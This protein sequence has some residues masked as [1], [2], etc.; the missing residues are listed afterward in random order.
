MN[1]TVRAL[2]KSR[3]SRTQVIAALA[4][5]QQGE[6]LANLMPVLLNNVDESA[7]AFSHELLYGTL[8]QWWALSRIVESLAERPVDDPMVTAAL[9]VGLYQLLYLETP[10]YA[11][12]DSTLQAL[13]TVGQG[14]ATGFV[15][16]I[17]RKVQKSSNTYTKK[18][19]QHHSLPNWLAK[20]LKQDWAD[21]YAM[22]GQ[23]LR[24]PAPIFLRVNGQHTSLTDYC[25]L[26]RKHD[27]AHEIVPIGLANKQTIRLMDKIKIQ[28]LPHF[29]EGW[30]SVQD[31]H[32]QIAGHLLAA[33]VFD[34][35]PNRGLKILD[36]CAAP[37]GKTAHLLEL[38]DNNSKKFH[39][40]HLIA[41]DNEPIRLQRLQD[42][43][44]RLD[45]INTSTLQTVCA[46]AT[47]FA[48]GQYDAILLDAP[49]T[50]T[51]VIRRH[52]D[53]TLLRQ[54]QDVSQTVAL[55]AAILTNVWR[56]LAPNGYLLYA[57]CSLLKAENE[58]QIGAFLSQQND[59]RVVPFDLN[60]PNQ[61]ATNIGYQCLPLDPNGG[62]GFYYAL[63][64]KNAP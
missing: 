26:L 41:I 19:A 43:I 4:Q 57:T 3:D 13:K 7:R 62:D 36:A 46:D 25:A 23:A 61:I 27:I 1:D 37:G 51:G 42:N 33:C 48:Q 44:A 8:R 10:D 24:Q 47:T 54:A 59:A 11:A 20:Q 12:V 45:L 9:Q 18:V 56:L 40:E 34:P 16:A 52:P 21:H 29:A 58:Q 6:S 22:L 14:R 28:H 53:I 30:V 38:S 39:V 5:I 55:Q 64:Q 17:L 60:L 50:A 31:L 15:N 63:L 49:C 32:A 35:M 2:P